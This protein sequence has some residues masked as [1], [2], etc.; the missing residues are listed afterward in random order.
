MSE[1]SAIKPGSRYIFVK[2]GPEQP[3]AKYPDMAIYASM[4]QQRG[5]LLTKL[6]FEF[7]SRSSVAKDHKNSGGMV[8][9]V[10]PI[11]YPRS[12]LRA[13]DFLPIEVWGPPQIDASLGAAHLQAY[14]CS[15]A[16]NALAFLQSGGMDVTDLIVVPHA[17]DSLQGFGSVLIDFVQPDQDVI[18]F[19]LPRGRDEL[20]IGY[21]IDELRALYARL[22][23]IT[24]KS[25]SDKTL[26]ASIL[27]EEAADQV[28]ADLH[29]QRRSL[30]FDAYD[31]YRLIRS[32]EYL[33]AERFM[34][35]G[36]DALKQDGKQETNHI[37][38]LISGIVPEP[39]SLLR[40]IS[41]AGG[42]IVADDLASCGRRLYPAGQSQDPF[43]R[44]AERL[45]GGPPDPTLGNPISERL[46][47]LLDMTRRSS[48]RGVVF[49]SVKFCEPE[50]FDLPILRDGLQ[51]AGIP[52][53]AI[54]VDLSDPLSHQA[55]T[56]IEA[57]LEMIA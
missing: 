6:P 50:T 36:S 4:E 3:V 8:A 20:Q 1:P 28:L 34:E 15:V 19:Y 7:P 45:L 56:R 29:E 53:L 38:I 22:S 25:P 47:H 57:F 42:I 40:S 48:A 10:L 27:R 23:K 21:L 41:D 54:E 33:A 16:R 55:R 46:D 30:I 14:V 5:D 17:C 18:P 35:I 9:A 52:S 11:H 12:M 13:F 51:A 26:Y 49:Y 44:M 43:R 39:M 37:P 24:S 32:R 2:L 31:F